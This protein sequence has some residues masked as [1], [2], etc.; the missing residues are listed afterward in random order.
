M[1]IA[2]RAK[3]GVLGKV[4]GI[5][6]SFQ[7]IEAQLDFVVLKNVPF[8]LVIGRP[9]LKQLSGVLDFRSEE[10]RFAYRDQ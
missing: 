10:V 7:N 8:D 5:P 2:N 9:T 1:T 3:S 6:V 4:R